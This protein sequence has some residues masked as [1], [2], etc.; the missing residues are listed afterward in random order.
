MIGANDVRKM[1]LEYRDG[2]R[3]LECENERLI[4]IDLKLY[5]LGSPAYTDMPKNPSPSNDMV[6]VLVERKMKLE[7][8]MEKL[9]FSQKEKR[10]RYESYIDRLSTADQRAV[11]RMHYLDGIKW[12]TVSEGMYG[13]NEDFDDKR[14]A[15]MSRLMKLNKYSLQQ[16]AVII[17]DTKNGGR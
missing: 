11:L 10:E 15:Y 2:E 3:E 17:N 5:S 1:L 12:E 16:M 4:N 9:V 6:A 7:R 14:D 13:T 8:K